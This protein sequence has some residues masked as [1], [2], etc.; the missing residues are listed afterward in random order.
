MLWGSWKIGFLGLSVW[1]STQLPLPA[2]CQSILVSRLVPKQS[3]RRRVSARRYAMWGGA[4]RIL[5]PGRAGPGTCCG[6]RA[7]AGHGMS[8]KPAGR[9]QTEFL[10]FSGWFLFGLAH[11]SGNYE[12][13]SGLLK[14]YML[15]PFEAWLFPPK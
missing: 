8:S 2:E 5:A 12:A 15:Q 13:W 1:C 6:A 11:L 10:D 7:V 9:D 14:R 4:A 3:K